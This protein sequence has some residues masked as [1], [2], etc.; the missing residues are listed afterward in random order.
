MDTVGG[1]TGGVG[2]PLN[3]VI[4]KGSPEDLTFKGTFQVERWSPGEGMGVRE[5][6]IQKGQPES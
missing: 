1:V 6:M 4:Q 5:H 3:R 2:A